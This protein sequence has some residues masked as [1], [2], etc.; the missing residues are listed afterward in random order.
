MAAIKPAGVINESAPPATELS[1]PPT[2]AIENN[3]P[4]SIP[5]AA[6]PPPLPKQGLS[7]IEKLKQEIALRKKLESEKE[8]TEEVQTPIA[9]VEADLPVTPERFESAWRNY[10]LLLQEEKK[11]SLYAI[12]SNA[13]WEVTNPQTVEIILA[14]QHESEMFDEAR[15]HTIPFFRSNL[16]NTVFEITVKVVN[17][18]IFKR[19]FTAEEKFNVMAERNPAL[20]ELRKLLALDLE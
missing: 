4:A 8:Q 19:A 18:I 6:P 11:Q 14:S 2:P 12:L 5:T 1:V 20:I 7:S 13:R 3:K 17:N 16:K 10:L 15:I 9:S